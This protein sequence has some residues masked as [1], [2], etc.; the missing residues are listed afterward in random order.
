L[1]AAFNS[2]FLLIISGVFL[3]QCTLQIYN[4]FP[5]CWGKVAIFVVFIT[6]AFL[7]ENH[8]FRNKI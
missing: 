3:C 2:M 6:S 4:T 5:I 7:T 1:S 8:S